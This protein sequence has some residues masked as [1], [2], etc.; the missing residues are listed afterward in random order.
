MFVS[1]D[2]ALVGDGDG[3]FGGVVEDNTLTAKA[4][5]KA[6]IDG[7]VNEVLLFVRYFFQKIF[8]LFY[9]NVA[10]RAGAHPATVVVEV[11]IVFFSQFQNGFVL[12]I[13]RDSFGRYA[14]IFKQ[15]FYGSHGRGEPLRKSAQR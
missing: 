9:I 15:K 11:N 2:S 13:A 7:A 6:W 4:A 8:T 12:K 5:F 14:R 3:D 10:S 1:D